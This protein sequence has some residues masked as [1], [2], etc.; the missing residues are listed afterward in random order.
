MPSDIKGT[1]PSLQRDIC[2]F[3]GDAYSLSGYTPSDVAGA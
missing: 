2:P 1:K 3:L